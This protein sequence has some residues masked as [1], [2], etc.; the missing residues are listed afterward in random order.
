[1]TS[2]CGCVE[3]FGSLGLSS[4]K[5]LRRGDRAFTDKHDC[6]MPVVESTLKFA[7]T[8]F[9]RDV[10]RRQVC[11]VYD[12][13]CSGF[14]MSFTPCDRSANGLCGV[15]LAVELRGKRPSDFRSIERGLDVPFVI[16]ES[17]FS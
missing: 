7:V 15:A 4:G 1:M 10:N 16:G 13:G 9:F 17:H 3:A 5:R 12:A 2:T 11:G 8:A 14:E 6:W